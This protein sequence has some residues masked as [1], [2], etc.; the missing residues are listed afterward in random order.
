M[1][2]L[3]KNVGRVPSLHTKPHNPVHLVQGIMLNGGDL[4]T[5]Q[6]LY[7]LD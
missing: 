2:F 5:N 1:A 6:I 4:L 7:Y 3:S